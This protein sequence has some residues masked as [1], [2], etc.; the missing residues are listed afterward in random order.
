VLGR[1]LLAD[2]LSL[3]SDNH[4]DTVLEDVFAKKATATLSKRGSHLLEYFEF[5][6]KKSVQPL[7]LDESHFYA[8][9]KSERSTKS[10]TSAKSSKES[11]AFTISTLGL[12]GADSIAKSERVM[13]LCHRL[14]LLKSPTKQSKLLTRRNVLTLERTL[15]NPK[16]W[17]P[18]RVFAGHALW[19]LYGRLRWMDS[20]F[21]EGMNLDLS[22]DSKGYLESSSLRTKTSTT[23]QKKTTLL[24]QLAPADG[25][26]VQTWPRKWLA[27]RQRAKLA[28]PA[29]RDSNGE[30]LPL[31]LIVGNDGQF[32]RTPLSS[33]E[34]SRW[35]R[36]ILS[37]SLDSD[38]QSSEGISSHSLKSTTLAWTSKHGGASP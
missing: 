31:L 25:L 14:N 32:G 37:N 30:L 26:E 33:S 9:L 8:Y 12:D 21:S 7:P 29:T 5:C 24:P 2:I 6:R 35:L 17:L 23:A 11:I 22:E 15:Y 36:E 27:L 1:K 19:C 13:G 3:K 18:D 20:Q 38:E 4:I 28:K 16:A 10:A 34:A